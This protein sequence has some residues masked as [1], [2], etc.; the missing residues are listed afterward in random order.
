MERTNRLNWLIFLATGTMW[1]SS[2]LF[3]KLGV[4]TLTP[5]TLVA[6][7]LGVGATLLA[8]VLIA[9]RQPLPRNPR[10]YGHFAVMAIFSVV[11][12]FSLISWSE[13]SVSSSL[14]SILSGTVPLFVI[15]F[16]SLFL[17][18]ERFTFNRLAGLAV[19]FAGVVLIANPG[20][21]S[22]AGGVGPQVA[23]LVA[24]ASYAVGGVYARR[25]VGGLPPVVAATFQV[26]I[27]FAISSALALMFER[28][29][30]L[31]LDAQA[32]VSVLWLGI[33]GS[34]L[35][36]LGFF[37]L[38]RTWG[39]TRTSLVAYVMPVVGIALGVIVAGESI[40]LP[41][42]AGS[43]LVIG[44]IALVNMRTDLRRIITRTPRPATEVPA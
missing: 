38:L 33:F 2:Y 3:I 15:V 7:R 16:A 31:S 34:G 10:T 13:Q 21:L 24:A 36:Y 27:A 5:L 20:A 22:G 30:A 41:I 18:D 17:R 32:I 25:F 35:A 43:I 40:T 37:R 42:V 12:P 44:G 11:L 14:A 39:A 1:G 8:A 6:L 26:G 19:G 28:P 29:F 23:L 4:A 9:T